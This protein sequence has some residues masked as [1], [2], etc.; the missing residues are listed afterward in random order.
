[1]TSSEMSTAELFDR[2]RFWVHLSRKCAVVHGAPRPAQRYETESESLMSNSLRNAAESTVH[3]LSDFV[4]D[5][6][7][8]ASAVATSDL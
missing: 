7:A 3:M 5:T 1:M 8:T 6:L 2:S 4:D